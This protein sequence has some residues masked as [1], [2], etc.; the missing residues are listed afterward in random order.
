MVA[1]IVIQELFP[2]PRMLVLSVCGGIARKF[3]RFH[4]PCAL[5]TPVRSSPRAYARYLLRHSN[6][7]TG[8]VTNFR[9]RRVAAGTGATLNLS[10]LLCYRILTSEVARRGAR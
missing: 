10:A 5:R 9:K 6:H 7:L 4:G 3:L 8:H 2:S 1:A